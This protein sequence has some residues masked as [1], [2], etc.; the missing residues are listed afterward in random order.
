MRQQRSLPIRALEVE[1]P[2]PSGALIAPTQYQHVGDLTTFAQN[3]A[4]FAFDGCNELSTTLHPPWLIRRLWS[5]VLD[6]SIREVEV[7]GRLAVGAHDRRS[8]TMLRSP[9][10]CRRQQAPR[11][12]R[13]RRTRPGSPLPAR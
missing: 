11:A 8:V 5:D 1:G 6:L 13:R 7:E 2:Y 10:A 9:A 4:T 3:A 12:R